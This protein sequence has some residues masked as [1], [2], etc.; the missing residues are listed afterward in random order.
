M[1]PGLRRAACGSGWHGRRIRVC[2][3]AFAALACK[4]RGLSRCERCADRNVARRVADRLR[5]YNPKRRR[6]LNSA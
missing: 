4:Y 5:L 3:L 1:M 2:L 6:H